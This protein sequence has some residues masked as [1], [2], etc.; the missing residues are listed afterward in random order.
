MP[1]P[2]LE[3]SLTE[4]QARHLAAARTSAEAQ[5]ALQQG[6][7]AATENRRAAL[8]ALHRS[9][10]SLRQIASLVGTSHTVIADAVRAAPEVQVTDPRQVRNKAFG[11]SRRR[12]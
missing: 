3:E 1:T 12:I 2:E 10:L 9:G 5:L 6:I 8:S 7:E 4:D 11:G